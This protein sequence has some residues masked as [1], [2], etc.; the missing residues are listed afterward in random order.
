MNASVL[1]A[2]GI[3][4]TTLGLLMPGIRLSASVAGAG[5]A[6]TT[7]AIALRPGGWPWTTAA[8]IATFITLYIRTRPPRDNP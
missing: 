4:L 1:L 3:I 2:T 5:L 8:I 6:A 7:A